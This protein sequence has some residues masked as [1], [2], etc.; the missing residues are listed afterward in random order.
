MKENLLLAIVFIAIAVFITLFAAD[1]LPSRH[2]LHTPTPV[3]QFN[4][5]PYFLS[6]NDSLR[7]LPVRDYKNGD[8]YNKFLLQQKVDTGWVNLAYT[9][10]ATHDS[11]K[12]MIEHLFWKKEMKEKKEKEK[13]IDWSEKYFKN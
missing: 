10:A 12:D 9:F 13:P 8:L 7:I 6:I 1:K 5:E 11:E 3:P 2:T 4:E